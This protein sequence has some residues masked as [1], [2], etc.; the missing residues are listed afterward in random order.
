M[1]PLV[2]LEGPTASGKSELAVRLA[3]ELGTEIISADSR[4]VYR[5]LDIGT[6]KPLP[7]Q[8]R[9]VKH[10]LISIIDPSESYNAGRFRVDAATIT[11]RLHAE[12]KAPVVCGGTGLYVD[13]LLHGLFPQVMIDSELRQHLHNRLQSEGLAALYKELE[14]VDPAFAARISSNDRQRTLRGLEVFQATGIT[15]SEHWL[16]QEQESCYTAF[17]ILIDPPR[18]KLYERI[19]LRVI[20]MLE[21]GLLQEIRNVFAQ[22]FAVSAPGLNSVGYKEFLPHLLEGA[23]LRDCA[24]LAAQHTRNYAKRQC[25]WYRKHKFNLTLEQEACIISEIANPIRDWQKSLN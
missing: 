12:G 3:V 11:H 8:Q 2:T 10:H 22:G 17:R 4:Q 24:A 14:T 9:A 18:G 7:E 21:E 23:S 15:I 16:R 19:N 13:A 6:A 1:I 25:T 20:R 5:Y